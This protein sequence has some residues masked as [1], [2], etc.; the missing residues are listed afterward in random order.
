M[1]TKV[2]PTK[3]IHGNRHLNMEVCGVICYIDIF[4]VV[5]WG[6]VIVILILIGGFIKIRTW[7]NFNCRFGMW[8]SSVSFDRIKLL[9][10]FVVF[11]ME[12][13]VVVIILSGVMITVLLGVTCA[14]LIILYI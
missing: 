7:G 11:E 12:I 1:S 13:L 14:E 9:V 2:L 5:L 6:V 8:E 4:G 3:E 10:V